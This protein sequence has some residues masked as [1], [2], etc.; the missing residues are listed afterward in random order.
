MIGTFDTLT[1]DRIIDEAEKALGEPFSGVLIRM[2]SYI[3]R[4]YELMTRAGRR[5][6]AK[7][8]RPGRWSRSAILEEQLYTFEAAREDIPVAT[9]LVLCGGTT[10]G[11]TEEGISFSLSP[12]HGARRFDPTD[13]SSFERMGMILGRL[14]A[15]GAR[16]EATHRLRCSP[17]ECM[18]PQMNFLL[19]YVPDTCRAEVERAFARAARSASDKFRCAQS[20]RLHGDCHWN[21]ILLDSGENLMLIDFDDMMQGPAVQDL[22]LLLPGEPQDCPVEL[23][24]LLRGYEIFQPFDRRQ[25]ELIPVLRTMRKIYFLAW[26]ATQ[27]HDGTF[28]ENHPGW[29]SVGFWRE[30]LSG[31]D[32]E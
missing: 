8:Y 1:P 11:S 21:N 2:P 10:L 9:P 18:V 26:C 4:V 23:D 29:G 30:F 15:V 6:V 22:W 31:L 20:I 12:K 5:V 13:A 28:A 16:R 7:F 17:R 3:N 14:H 24:N 27:Y 32:G 19:R 25:L